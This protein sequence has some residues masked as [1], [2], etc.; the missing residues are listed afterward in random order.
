[1]IRRS[2]WHGSYTLPGNG[3]QSTKKQWPTHAVVWRRNVAVG[4]CASAS[5]SSDAIAREGDYR[6]SHLLRLIME[7][8]SHA[9]DA[10]KRLTVSGGTRPDDDATLMRLVTL[11]TSVPGATRAGLRHERASSAH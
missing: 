6:V 8:R 5:R 9:A 10:T 2:E 1:M 7:F 4:P 3:A 11:S